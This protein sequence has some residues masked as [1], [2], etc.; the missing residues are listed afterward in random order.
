MQLLF[1]FNTAMLKYAE[2]EPY[3]VGVWLVLNKMAQHVQWGRCAPAHTEPMPL[4]LGS[5]FSHQPCLCMD[6]L[7]AGM[8]AAKDNDPQLPV[9]EEHSG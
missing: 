4:F 2:P 3:K 7:L 6:K 8:F 5:H 1:H 9:L